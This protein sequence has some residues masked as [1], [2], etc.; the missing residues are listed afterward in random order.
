[1]S[2][3]NF[4]FTGFS[5][6]GNLPVNGV[7]APGQTYTVTA[8][9]WGP[10][11]PAGCLY[12]VIRVFNPAGQIDP[13]VTTSPVFESPD[14]PFPYATPVD[15]THTTFTITVGSA[16]SNQVDTLVLLCESCIYSDSYF[17]VPITIQAPI[18]P[19][20]PPVCPAPIINSV[21]PNTWIAGEKT[22]ITIAGSCFTNISGILAVTAAGTSVTVSTYTV[23]S[24]GEIT[25]TVRPDASEPTENATLSVWDTDEQSDSITVQIVAACNPQITSVLPNNWFAGKTYDN[26]VVKG[27]GFITTDKATATCPETTVSIVAADG[28]AVPVSYVNVVD[29]TK[30]TVSVAP[31]ANN[32]TEQATVTVSNGSNTG[33]YSNANVLG[34]QIICSGAN[35]ACNGNVISATDGSESAQDAVVGQPIYLTTPALPSGITATKTTWTVGGT[36]GTNIGS[37]TSSN[38]G[39]KTKDTVLTKPNATFYWLSQGTGIPITYQYCADIPGVGNQ[40]SPIATATFNV[41]APSLVNLYTCGG[42]VTGCSKYGPLGSVDITPGPK[43]SL[44]NSPPSNIGIVFNASDDSSSPPGT[45]SFVQLIGNYTTVYNYNSGKSCSHN[46]G[47]GLDNSN[48]YP[49]DS[50]TIADDNPDT[51]LFADDTE[52]TA[53][54]TAT[55]YLLWTSS[56]AGSIPVPLGYVGWSW[57]GDAVQDNSEWSINASSQGTSGSFTEDS[58]YPSWGKV[59]HN[60][61][62][63]CAK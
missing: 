11:S 58:D 17:D 39:F 21:T 50:D 29:K 28:S 52:V 55:M 14:G 4:Y 8:G 47:S 35:M 43:L 10:T 34:N 33:T 63:R 41:S 6:T 7:L 46:F 30:I 40:C 57:F 22:N 3:P 44:G 61:A 12:E 13:N 25:A 49:P 23:V 18:P 27:S 60:G 20:P 54:M 53:D 31:P 56:V 5:Y 62:N 19:P 32:P 45:F 26:V 59:L 37:L 24:S 15:S 48:P 9:G 42:D 2:D 16:A 51:P 36:G 38:K 1:M